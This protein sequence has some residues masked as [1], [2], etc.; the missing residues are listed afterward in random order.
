M[1]FTAGST[2]KIYN[3]KQIDFNGGEYLLPSNL[4]EQGVSVSFV[5]DQT[6]IVASGNTVVKNEKA[7]I[8]FNVV[9]DALTIV[10]L[11]SYI[12]NDMGSGSYILIELD[13]FDS[14]YNPS[15]FRINDVIIQA[16]EV[17]KAND[18]L[19]LVCVIEINTANVDNVIN[20][21]PRS[22]IIP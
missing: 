6:A 12:K 8:S 7:T 14:L 16:N 17:V 9:G 1:A 20:F 13:D 15:Y 5:P 4:I 22:L 21:N 18:M 2:Y 10:G 19:K 11:T 3:L